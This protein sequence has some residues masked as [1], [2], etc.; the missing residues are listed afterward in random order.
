[1]FDSNPD[2]RKKLMNKS[3]HTILYRYKIV[4][5]SLIFHAIF[6][7]PDINRSC[8]I[9]HSRE[10]LLN[11]LYLF[12]LMEKEAMISIFDRTIEAHNP[13][14]GCNSLEKI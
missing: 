6:R 9:L 3:H 12:H 11:K 14:I 5:I 7:L 1:M 8:Q 2:N 13:E 10:S 4:N